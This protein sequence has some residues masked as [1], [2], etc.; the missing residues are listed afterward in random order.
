MGA[1]GFPAAAREAREK[2]DAEPDAEPGAEPV[3]AQ[4]EASRASAPRASSLRQA[5]PRPP[6]GSRGPGPEPGARPAG[7]VQARLPGRHDPLGSRP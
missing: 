7:T 3:E 1:N 5:F 2:P 4:E 6:P